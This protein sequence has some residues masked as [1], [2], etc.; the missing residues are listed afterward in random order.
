M[1]SN[2]KN[3]VTYQRQYLQQ[4]RHACPL[5]IMEYPFVKDKHTA[6]R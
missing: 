3:E 1:I 6:L 5:Y 4:H 2:E